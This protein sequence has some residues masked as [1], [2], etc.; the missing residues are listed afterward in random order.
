M[1]VVVGLPMIVRWVTRLFTRQIESNN[2]QLM[3]IPSGHGRPRQLQG[4]HGKNFVK[5]ILAAVMKKKKKV[6]KAVNDQFGSP[7]WTHRLAL[8]IKELIRRDAMGTYHA[9]SEGHCSP[10]QCAAYVF[11]TLKVKV[12]IETMSLADYPFTAKRP[13]NCILENRLLKKQGSNIMPAWKRDMK[14]F[15]DKNKKDL[16]KEARSRKR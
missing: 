8:Q 4:S 14:T 6:L 3:R 15:L 1:S 11:D 7:T 9:T 5:S 10:A 13:V 16:I 2:G 12:K